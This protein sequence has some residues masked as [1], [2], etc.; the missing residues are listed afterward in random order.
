MLAVRERELADV[1]GE[2][3]EAKAD[4][5]RDDQIFTDKLRELKHVSKS[6]AA[7]QRELAALQEQWGAQRELIE[8]LQAQIA[9]APAA[10]AAAAA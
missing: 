4:L 2:L 7:L 10:A 5:A 8:Q 9:H 3:A 1:R 6:R